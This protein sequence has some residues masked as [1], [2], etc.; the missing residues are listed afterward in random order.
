MIIRVS[1]GTASNPGPDI[2]DELMTTE[3]VGIAR[4]RNELDE[5]GSNKNNYQLSLPF[6]TLVLP[7][8]LVEVA[9]SGYGAAWR[10]KANSVSISTNKHAV[11]MQ[12]DVEVS[13]I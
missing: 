1:R 11:L 7:G 3:L 12:L 2:I 6:L 10:G 8:A 9:D 13:L 5:H 4:G